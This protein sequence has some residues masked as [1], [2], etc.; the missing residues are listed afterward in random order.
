MLADEASGSGGSNSP[1]RLRARAPEPGLDLEGGESGRLVAAGVAR[2]EAQ[3]EG[4]AVVV[5][6]TLPGMLCSLAC[7]LT[8][9]DAG[10]RR[11]SARRV[12]VTGV[13]KALCE[14][15]P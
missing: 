1:T 7:M 9:G 11:A 14:L 10:A 2:S 13:L 8:V 5:R 4:V 3:G 6:T 12:R 15:V